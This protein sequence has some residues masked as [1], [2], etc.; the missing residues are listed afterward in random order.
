[1]EEVAI[2]LRFNR[3]CLGAAKRRQGDRSIFCMDRD[4]AGRVMFMP[5]AW[6]SVMVY[7]AKLANRHQ[8]LVKKI[9]WCPT[10]DG[11]PSREWRRTIPGGSHYALHEAFMPGDEIAVTAVLPGGI[12]SQDMQELLEIVGK[13]KGFS[14][15]NNATEKFGTFEVLR[16]T[17]QRVA[18]TA[19]PEDDVVT[20]K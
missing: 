8:A 11:Q 10:I 3:P 18:R 14:P 12:S 15:F 6:Q 13:Y 2:R 17:S 16:V 7:A 20:K 1:M 9:D 19:E 5:A 4:P